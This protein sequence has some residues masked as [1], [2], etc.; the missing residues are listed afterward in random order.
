M[1]HCDK[2]TLAI[3]YE[4]SLIIIIINATNLCLSVDTQI[5]QMVNNIVR[6]VWYHPFATLKLLPNE[7]SKQYRWKI[8]LT[9]G[10]SQMLCIQI[11]G[12]LWCLKDTIRLKRVKQKEDTSCTGNIVGYSNFH[13]GV[14]LVIRFWYEKGTLHCLKKFRLLHLINYCISRFYCGAAI[15][16]CKY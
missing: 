10:I 1:R 15:Q 11:Y 7:G 4:F 9:L 12:Y 6:M 13:F 8:S 5:S 16:T 3:E 2:K 14:Q